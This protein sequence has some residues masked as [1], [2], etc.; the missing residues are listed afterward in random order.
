MIK[1]LQKIPMVQ[2]NADDKNHRQVYRDFVVNNTW[3]GSPFRFILEDTYINIPTMIN[4]KLLRHYLDK[5]FKQVKGV[6]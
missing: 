5:E 3:S 6:K 4:D 2:F 1:S